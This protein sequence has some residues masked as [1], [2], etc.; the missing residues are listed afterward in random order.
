MLITTELSFNYNNENQFRYPA[1]E[2]NADKPLLITGKSGCGKTTLLH[3]LGGLLQ[4]KE[5]EIKIN[6]TAIT[7]LSSTKRD[8]FRGQQIGIIF[9]KSH[10]IA[11]MNVWDNIVMSNYCSGKK[12]SETD[13]KQIAAYLN[14][15]KLLYKPVLQLS[16]GEQQRVSI[17]RAVCNKPALL[18]ADEPTSSLDDENAQQVIGLLKQLSTIVSSTLI[19]V[20]HDERIKKHFSNA[21]KL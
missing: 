3:L 1:M 7:K 14:I 16:Q 12:A 17:A 15:E 18:L 19:I 4:P 21:I 2:A 13:I 20:T 6:E 11:S 10:F 9:Q 8:D 5:G